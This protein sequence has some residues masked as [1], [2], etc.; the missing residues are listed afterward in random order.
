MYRSNGQRGEL[1]LD[2]REHGFGKGVVRV[3]EPGDGTA[4]SVTEIGFPIQLS[5]LGGLGCRIACCSDGSI[6]LQ[7]C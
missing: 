6:P 2:L 1:L 7:A 4:Q 3:P 5:A